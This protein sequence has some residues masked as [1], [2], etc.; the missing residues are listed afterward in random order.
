MKRITIGAGILFLLASFS[1]CYGQLV[2]RL[3][4]PALLESG[5]ANVA[6]IDQSG[7]EIV[8]VTQVAIS[9][10]TTINSVTVFST[11][12]F[13]N[14]PDSSS[15]ILNIF[16]GTELELSDDTLSGGDL[17][18]VVSVDYVRTD[19]GIEITASGLDIKLPASPILIG[20]TPLLSFSANGQEFL[21]DAGS[22]GVTTFLNNPGGA[23]FGPIFGDS[24]INANQVD[25]PTPF[26]GMAIRIADSDVLKGDVNRDG[27][28]TLADISPFVD[29]LS[30]GTY[31]AEADIDCNG[32]VNLQDI[33]LF[34]Q[35]LSGG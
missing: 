6:Y 12:L 5:V 11:N 3:P 33:P 14:Y 27:Q 21:Q 17:G 29:A 7:Q 1:V 19:N 35:L 18:S 30:S 28:I 24:T 8:A 2:E 15:A 34:V 4:D 9:E 10:P 20:L 31:V 13:D 16:L 26:T 22:N 25:L 23:I 32:V